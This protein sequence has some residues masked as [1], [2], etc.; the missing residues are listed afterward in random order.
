MTN[1]TT[2]ATIGTGNAEEIAAE[3]F[4]RARK[5]V[6]RTFTESGR[7]KWLA[8]NDMGE[9]SRISKV[10][11]SAILK[12][13]GLTIETFLAEQEKFIN[14][15][16]AKSFAEM[17]IE[18]K[19]RFFKEKIESE[20]KALDDESAFTLLPKITALEDDNEDDDDELI[21]E[22]ETPL[23]EVGTPITLDEPTAPVDNFD[24]QVADAL[25]AAHIAKAILDEKD[26]VVEKAKAESR[27]A[28]DVYKAAKAD[29][30]K[31]YE[32]KAAELTAKIKP[33]KRFLKVIKQD[34]REDF[35][36]KDLFVHVYEGY[37]WDKHFSTYH[38][39]IAKYD[40]RE[41]N[42]LG[43]YDTPT[44]VEAVILELKAA[45]K[46]GDTEFTFPTVDELSNTEISEM[47]A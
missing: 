45:I 24:T 13:F 41:G 6:R 19:A 1:E 29:I 9:F 20:Q 17:A 8:L 5:I 42:R 26:A 16:V 44:Q 32:R 18:N 37:D 43:I 39:A 35:I 33:P 40:I 30:L 15:E 12:E 14:A 27:K 3:K 23:I 36:R 2:I 46:R 25:K 38:F 10:T 22:P 31:L 28:C 7:Q 4:Q 21:D 34:G 11:A 47:T